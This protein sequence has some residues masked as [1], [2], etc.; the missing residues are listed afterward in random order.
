MKIFRDNSE[1]KHVILINQNKGG[2][3]SKPAIFFDRDGVIIEDF[4]YL[5]N[6]KNVKLLPGVKGLLKHSNK[7]GWFNIL[8]TNQ[9]GIGRGYFNWDNYEKITKKY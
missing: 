6:P 8:I 3:T 1:D 5:S 9:S 2:S 7:H 4:H